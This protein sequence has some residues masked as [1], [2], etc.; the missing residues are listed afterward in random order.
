M[1]P[2][3]LVVTGAGHVGSYVLA[4]AMKA[5]LF[6]EIAVIDAD[7]GVARG[8]AMDQLHATALPSLTSVDVHPGTPGD[9]T[10][11]D[12]IICAAGQSIVKDPEHPDAEPDRTL[13]TDVSSR[14]IRQVMADI[15]SHTH[16]AIVILITNPLDTMVYIAEN[17]FGYPSGRVLGTGTMLDSARL[18]QAIAARLGISPSSVS[19]YMMGEHG[20]TAFPV[21]SRVSIG[22][23]RWDELPSAF[24]DFAPIT[25]EQVRRQVVK[26]AFDLLNAKGWTNAGVAQSAVLLARAVVL[27]EQAIWPASSTLH[28]EYGH[29]G[30]VALSMPSV[31]GRGGLERRIPV[32]LD[33]WESAQLQISIDYVQQTIAAAGAGNAALVGH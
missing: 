23:L 19:G 29:D 7:D 24:P 32:T 18:R 1:K 21:L 27:D 3:K 9:Y 28:G 4:D 13:L 25:P 8:E 16:D 33:D 11:A 6:A 31:I 15:A 14:V 26:A 2:T 12:I 20:A 17:E 5:G 30:D 10:D 22:G